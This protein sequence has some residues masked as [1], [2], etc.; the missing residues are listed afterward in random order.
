LRREL[1]RKDTILLSLVQRVPELEPTREALLEP[2]NGHETASEEQGNGEVLQGKKR[3][4][5]WR[6]LF[7]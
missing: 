4:A 7:S 3:R 6:R 2:R 1:E 5:W